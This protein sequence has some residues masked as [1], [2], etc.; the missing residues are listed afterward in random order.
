MV[1]IIILNHNNK[2]IITKCLD[3][4]IKYSKN[5]EYELIVVDN[6]STDGSLELLKTLY[7]DKIILLENSVNGGC[8]NKF[9]G[10]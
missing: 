9:G 2:E 7:K 4:V 3:S 8:S 5:M 6:R 10:F 1:S